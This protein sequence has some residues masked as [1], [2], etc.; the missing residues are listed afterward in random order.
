[1]VVTKTEAV[2]KT[3]YKVYIDGKF[4]F[5][6][7]KGELSRYRVTAGE[8]IEREVYD[9]IRTEVILKRAKLR[10]LHLLNDMGRTE[11]QLRQ[12][13]KSS[14]YPEDIV[15]QAVSYV[16]S[17]GYINDES[18]AR[19]FII[20]RKEKKSRKELYAQLLTKGIGK[21]VLQTVFEECYEEDDAVKAITEILRKKGYAPEE[22][23]WKETRKIMGYLTRKGF[24]YED[25]RQVIQVSDWNA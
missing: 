5:V 22:A 8:E 16:K 14:D 24:S 12:K 1:M 25:I 2:T 13:L 7:Y 20:S 10:A 17:F 3:K 9:R 6:L 21:E 23:D 18:Y 4:A 15:E 11:H 19:S